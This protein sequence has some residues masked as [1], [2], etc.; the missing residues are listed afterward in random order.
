LVAQGIKKTGLAVPGCPPEPDDIIEVLERFT[1]LYPDP[2]QRFK[3]DLRRLARFR[4]RAEPN[5]GAPE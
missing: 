5:P 3:Q 1:A 4:L 2:W